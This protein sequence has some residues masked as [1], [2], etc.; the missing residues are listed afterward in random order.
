MGTYIARR[1]GYAVLTSLAISL[2][3]FLI[4]QL[5]P[6][7]F[8][9]HYIQTQLGAGQGAGASGNIMGDPALEAQLR[10]EFGLD[11]PVSVQYIRW[12]QRIL[13]GDWG[14]SFSFGRPIADVIADRLT[15]TIIL[16]VATILFTWVLSIPIGIY[17]ATHQYTPQDYAVTFVGFLGLA[18][19]NF[20]LALVLLWAGALVFGWEI[21][22][23]YA[24]EYLNE[25]W[26]WAKFASMLPRLAVPAI[27]L[28]TAGAAS[29][30]RITRNNL[31]DELGKQYVMSARAK[32]VSERKLV[33]KYPLRLAINPVISNAAYLFPFLLSGDVIVGQVLSLPTVGPVLLQAVL[34]EDL[35]LAATV[36]L[37]LGMLTVIGTFISD[38]MLAVTDPR[39]RMG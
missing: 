8:A 18:V 3:A 23:L 7:D 27:V 30:I 20:L 2:V 37:W 10:A 17:S 13:T 15:N 32:G 38:L 1:F 19:P 21:G 16:A 14:M 35:Y 34:S 33:F 22:G 11:R 29:L 9:T 12:L 24:P 25:P 4:V 6:G 28:G 39:I 31:L 36:F 26:S 5:P